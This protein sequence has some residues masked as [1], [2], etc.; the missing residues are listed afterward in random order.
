MSKIVFGE[1]S[2]LIQSV[3]SLSS[4]GNVCDR[5]KIIIILSSTELKCDPL[6]KVTTENKGLN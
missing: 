3:R 1:V 5:K 6:D 2:N 4:C